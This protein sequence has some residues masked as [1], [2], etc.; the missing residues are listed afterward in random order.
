MKIQQLIWKGKV[1][2]GFYRDDD[3]FI[4]ITQAR[5]YFDFNTLKD[6]KD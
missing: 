6:K 3:L 5:K 4:N 2:E 1:I